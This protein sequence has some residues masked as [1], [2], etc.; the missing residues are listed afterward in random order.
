[1]MKLKIFPFCFLTI[2]MFSCVNQKSE[3]LLYSNTF[4]LKD[5]VLLDGPFKHARDL[6]I[7]TLLKYDTDR[8][9]ATYL[10][11]AGLPEKASL[12]PNWEGLDGHVTGHYLSALAMNYASTGNQ[13][14][15]ELM[16]YMILELKACQDAN[17]INHPEWGEGYAGG[18]PD[19]E[20]IWSN[21]RKGNFDAYR[22]AWVPW[23]NVHKMY[24]GLRDAWYYA[25]NED[26]K[27]IFLK[28][29]DWGINI[30]SDLTEEQMQSMLDTEHG[31]MNE[32]FAD[33]YR[34]S[35]DEK[36][37]TAARRFSHRM[38]L[39]TMSSG[40]DNLDNKHA[41]TQVPKATGFQ[42]ITELS[43]DS[44]YADAGRFFWETVTKNRSLAFGG[45]SRRE[46]FPP[47]SEYIDFINEVQGPESCNSHN[48]LRLTEHLFRTDPS[49]KYSDYYERTM[50]NHILSTQHPEHG[51]YV[52]FTPARPRHYRVYSAPNEAM[53]CCVGSGMENHGKYNQFIYT[54]VR[55]SL[56]LNLFVASEL[57]WAK[58]DILLRQETNF[59]YEEFTRL[60]ITKGSSQFVL[61]I[62]YP[63]WVKDG[64][65]KITVNGNP[66]SFNEHPSSYISIDRKWKE[67]DEV[68]VTFPMHTSVE[69]LPNIPDYLAFFHGPVLLG[70]KTGTEDL[71]G[72]IA[73]DSRWGHIASGE[74]L[75]VDEAPAIINT[76]K[77]DIT[78]MI[79]PVQ[80]KPLIFTLPSS[81]LNSGDDMILEPFYRIHDSRYII[82]WKILTNGK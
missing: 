16:E 32:I 6:N 7:Q 30:T 60:I 1:M 53:W 62:R 34:I 25:E 47:E 55:D 31:G 42:R 54:H 70:A 10:K 81:V 38:L 48:M 40:T 44:K 58:K 35:G 71:K 65:L 5:V 75:P 72:L 50:L 68:L 28:F 41:N 18:V 51:G 43:G 17:G 19:S 45:N 69:Q 14:C 29:C 67:G 74:R 3:D 13:E 63:S 59:P 80:D 2:L 9:L 73:D 78:E 46:H 33:A 37:L 79:I 64:D 23:Y 56:F 52:Y 20:T 21:L 49:A 66:V 57:N 22:S 12:Y 39:D 61:M 36:Y 8:L 15:K 26:A 77:N 24:A 76:N 27:D 82:Y 11:E 4:S